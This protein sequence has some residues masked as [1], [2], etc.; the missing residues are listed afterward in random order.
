MFLLTV[1]RPEVKAA[2]WHKSL[3]ALLLS[4]NV[5]S[6]TSGGEEYSNRVKIYPNKVCCFDVSR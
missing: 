3:I 6:I 1:A 2:F 4:Q 5:Y